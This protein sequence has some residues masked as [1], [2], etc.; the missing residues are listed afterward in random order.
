MEAKMYKERIKDYFDYSHNQIIYVELNELSSNNSV[1]LP[2][3][4]TKVLKNGVEVK[5][6]SSTKKGERGILNT[7]KMDSL[8]FLSNKKP[9][10]NDIE[11]LV[12]YLD[13]SIRKE[14]FYVEDGYKCFP[15]LGE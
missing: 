1:E 14:L 7:I 2:G 8:D 12:M 13:K 10:K 15:F 3:Y 9:T 5:F 11:D 6:S 4:I